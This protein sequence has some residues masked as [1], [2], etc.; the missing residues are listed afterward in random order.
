MSGEMV[1]PMIDP[2]GPLKGKGVSLAQWDRDAKDQLAQIRAEMVELMELTRTIEARRFGLMLYKLRAAHQLRWRFTSKLDNG[3]QGRHATWE[4][5]QP[6]LP[7]L[8]P[9]LASWYEEVNALAVVLNHKEQVA[10]YQC[11][12]VQRLLDGKV[13][14]DLRLHGTVGR[15]VGGGRPRLVSS[16]TEN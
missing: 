2:K 15:G 10:R 5:L 1:K 6:L 3:G 14:K 7:Q 8:S 4:A 11:K 12:T 9:V 16:S 13:T